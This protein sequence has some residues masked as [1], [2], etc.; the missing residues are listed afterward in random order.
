MSPSDLAILI[1]EL[2]AIASQLNAATSRADAA[3][4]QAESLLQ[5]IGIGMAAEVT[6]ASQPSVAKDDDGN[7][8]VI[9]RFSPAEQSRAVAS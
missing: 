3:V 5:A 8:V 2:P 1:T 9:F 7:E 6:I 4:T